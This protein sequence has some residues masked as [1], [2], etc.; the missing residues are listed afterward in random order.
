M[1][2]LE[3]L[4][5]KLKA[6]LAL[7]AAGCMGPLQSL[8][9]VAAVDSPEVLVQLLRQKYEDSDREVVDKYSKTVAWINTPEASYAQACIK[10]YWHDCA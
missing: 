10:G 8:L 4:E 5:D 1:I 9:M 3:T 7:H 2:A 6:G